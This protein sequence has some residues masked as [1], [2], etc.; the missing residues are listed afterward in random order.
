MHSLVILYFVM[1]KNHG[2]GSG[3]A[4]NLSDCFLFKSLSFQKF[5]EENSSITYWVIL[6]KNE[7]TNEQNEKKEEEE[8][9]LFCQAKHNKKKLLK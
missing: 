1:W 6:L 8:E 3:T 2:F 7:A 9:I 5:H 4:Q